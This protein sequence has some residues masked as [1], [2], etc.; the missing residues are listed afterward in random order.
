MRLFHRLG[1]SS[2]TILGAACAGSPPPD[3]LAPAWQPSLLLLITI[4]QM[5]PDYYDR[6]ERELT[7]G[8]ARMWREGANFTDAHHDHAITETAPGHATLLTGRFPR[9][10]GITRNL[11]GVNDPRWPV[12]WSNDLGAAPFRLRGT[13]VFDWLRARDPA[14]RALSASAKDRSAILPVGS[15]KQQVYWYTN[16]GLFSTST[17]YRDTLP[18]WVAAFNARRVPPN[19]GPGMEHPHAPEPLPGTR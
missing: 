18:D 17:W 4:D 1:I 15:S 7:G 6:F 11:A 14:T 12:L 13:T 5:R 10:T 9:G 19:G 3:P 16:N 8:L 2:A